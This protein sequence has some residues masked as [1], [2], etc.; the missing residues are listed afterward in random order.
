MSTGLVRKTALGLGALYAAL[1]VLGF[2]A[3]EMVGPF[4]ASPLVSGVYLV[5][6]LIAVWASRVGD[7]TRS[8]MTALALVFG[9]L[10]VAGLVA[11][12]VVAAAPATI[13]LHAVTALIAAYLAF[14]ERL[15]GSGSARA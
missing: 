12:Q 5:A 9:A 2:V 7:E 13:L 6:G 3:A 8:A 10:F 4:G 14:G 1:G 11:P 15:L